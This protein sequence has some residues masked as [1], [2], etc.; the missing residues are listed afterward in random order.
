MMDT[1]YPHDLRR[2]ILL[3]LACVAANKRG[4]HDECFRLMKER[5]DTYL[6][7]N[8]F[9]ASAYIAWG[10]GRMP[11]EVEADLLAGPRVMTEHDPG[12]EQPSRWN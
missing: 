4:A 9:D 6:R 8:A 7:L 1:S 2:C 3:S 12:D 10:R 11:P 5:D